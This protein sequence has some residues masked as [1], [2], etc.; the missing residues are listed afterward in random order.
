MKIVELTRIQ[1]GAILA[2]SIF[3][4][5]GRT[6]L[7]KGVSLSSS[8]ATRL[9]DMGFRYVYVEDA[10]TADIQGEDSIPDEIRQEVLGRLEATFQKLQA[11][12]GIQ[13]MVNSGDLGREVLSIY[14]LLY[15]HLAGTGTMMVNL[16]ALYSSDAHTY[17]H[18][19]NVAVMATILGLAQGYSK[20]LVEELGVGAMMHDIGKI[21]V[22]PAIL[23]KPD[24]LTELEY[25]EV[26]RHTRLG[27]DILRKQPDLMPSCAICALYHHEWYD[28]SGYPEGLKGDGIP[29]FARLMAVADVYDALT[30]NRSYRDAWLPSD[31]L[32]FMFT[33]TYQQFD[34]IFIRSFVKHVNVYPPGLTVR[35]SN[36]ASGVVARPNDKSLMRPYILVTEEDGQ[37]VTPYEFDLASNLNVT[38]LHCG[39]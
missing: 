15:N 18:C 14:R 17:T 21:E 22:S 26:K 27:H 37:P 28:G 11:P 12:D 20:E 36:K 2:K 31:A 5:N 3:T 16:S 10:A 39:G 23:N 19:M 7:K 29:E 32:E 13:T 4:A 38:I 25:A 1:P 8:Y 35:L 6:L 33:R 24:K 34:P 30:A 9:E